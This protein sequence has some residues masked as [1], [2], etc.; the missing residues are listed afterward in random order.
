MNLCF[1]CVQTATSANCPKNFVYDWSFTSTNNNYIQDSNN[2]YCEVPANIHTPPNK[3][4]SVWTKCWFLPQNFQWSSAG[5]EWVFVWN[6]VCISAKNHNARWNS[7]ARN[8]TTSK[9]C[10]GLIKTVLKKLTFPLLIASLAIPTTSLTFD[11]IH[12]YLKNLWNKNSNVV[13]H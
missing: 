5:K 8:Y 11:A 13:E 6:H 10:Y 7:Y 12:K 9:C 1:T 2:Y 3:N 4:I